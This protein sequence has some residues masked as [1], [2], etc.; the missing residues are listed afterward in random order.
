[1]GRGIGFTQQAR[2]RAQL[3]KRGAEHSRSRL[4]QLLGQADTVI[5]LTPSLHPC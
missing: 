4:G 3:L 2:E 5:L 1:M